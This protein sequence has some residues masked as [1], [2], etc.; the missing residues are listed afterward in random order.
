MSAFLGTCHFQQYRMVKIMW[1]IFY[2]AREVVFSF[3]PKITVLL[4]PDYKIGPSPQMLLAVFR[5]AFLLNFI[6]INQNLL[7]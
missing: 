1:G 3:A 5:L 7:T 6:K 4:W 2:N